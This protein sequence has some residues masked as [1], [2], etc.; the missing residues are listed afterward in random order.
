MTLL[1]QVNKANKFIQE[2]SSMGCQ[3]GVS[4]DK[5]TALFAI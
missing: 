2:L 3:A 5:L 1:G 4:L